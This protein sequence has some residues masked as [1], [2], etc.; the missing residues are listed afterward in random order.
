MGSDL[1]AKRIKLVGRLPFLLQIATAAGGDNVTVEQ[2]ERQMDRTPKMTIAALKMTANLEPEA[3]LD[4]AGK[5]LDLAS[6][7]DK[8]A[9]K[10]TELLAGYLLL[11]PT[12][13]EKLRTVVAR[14]EVVLTSVEEGVIKS[15]FSFGVALGIRNEI[16]LK[17]DLGR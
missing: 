11:K 1:E 8:G 14:R 4:I 6:T 15:A 17:R 5:I 10:A 13:L 12:A 3:R 9:R 7:Q 2:W 16:E